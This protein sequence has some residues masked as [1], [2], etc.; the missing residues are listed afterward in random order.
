MSPRIYQLCREAVTFMAVQETSLEKR[1]AKAY[2]LFLVHVGIDDV[3]SDQH[4]HLATLQKAFENEAA[5][6]VGVTELSD[7]EAESLS[8]HVVDLF[9]GVADHFHDNNT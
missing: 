6:T 9:T 3:P 2:F 1:I 8:R 4:H 5:G 7:T